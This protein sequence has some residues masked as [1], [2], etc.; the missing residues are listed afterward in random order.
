MG[1][2]LILI[3]NIVTLSLH[4][5]CDAASVDESQDSQQQSCAQRHLTCCSPLFSFHGPHTEQH[6]CTLFISVA[7]TLLPLCHA[8]KLVC[9]RSSLTTLWVA[10]NKQKKKCC[11]GDKASCYTQVMD[12]EETAILH[13]EQNVVFLSWHFST[14]AAHLIKVE[15][16]CRGHIS[17]WTSCRRTVTRP[18]TRSCADQIQRTSGVL[19]KTSISN[20]EYGMER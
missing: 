6:S 8:V 17:A 10:L 18:G 9:H 1:V 2:V 4:P 13:V 19:L 15:T 12:V 5:A 14:T 20:C 3:P 11:W 16:R 7:R